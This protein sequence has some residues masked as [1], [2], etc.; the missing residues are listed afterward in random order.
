VRPVTP[1]T[2]DLVA[3]SLVDFSV[4]AIEETDAESWRVFFSTA[5]DRDNASRALS[6]QFPD[7]SVL[8]VEIEDE[9]WAVKSQADLKAVQV[10][11]VIVAPPWD[12]PRLSDQQ[13]V[14]VVIQ[15]S[16][17][18]GTGH[19]ATTR[20]CLAALQQIDLEP[21]SV[22]DIGTGSG[23]LAIAA[24]R[25]GAPRVIAIDDDM[26]AIQAMR[27]NLELNRAASVIVREGDFRAA[28]FEPFNVITANL[29]GALLGTAVD[30]IQ[31]LTAPGGRV[32]LSG[33]T[34]DEEGGLLRAY[35]G[36]PIMQRMQEDEWVCVTL[37]R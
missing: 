15:P 8:R 6:T 19:H 37:Q 2:S 20:L 30:R 14:V 7:L 21:C 23:V 16:M 17:G 25:L 34:A 36:M 18:F 27:E 10:G 12:I 11:R 26:D 4:A 35:S 5:L 28:T 32:I 3:A 33:F 9:D 31:E 29:T 22:L 24:S 13:A 1:A